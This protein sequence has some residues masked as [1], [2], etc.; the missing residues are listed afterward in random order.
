MLLRN[1]YYNI[2]EHT[3]PTATPALQGPKLRVAD[4]HTGNPVSIY[5]PKLQTPRLSQL[6]NENTISETIISETQHPNNPVHF[7]AHT[8]FPGKLLCSLRFKVGVPN[9]K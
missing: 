1:L 5:E 6:H 9:F 4:S 8:C 3:Q 2:R 7:V